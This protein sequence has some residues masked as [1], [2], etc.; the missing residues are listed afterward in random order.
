MIK[1]KDYKIINEKNVK[2]LNIKFVK[3]RH[4]DPER[5]YE[6]LKDKNLIKGQRTEKI[7]VILS[8]R[9]SGF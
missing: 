9:Q 4:F 6:K 2:I 5:F 3:R 8:S 7:Y 1:Q